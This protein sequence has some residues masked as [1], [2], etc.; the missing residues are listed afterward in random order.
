M[1]KGKPSP[2]VETLR[3]KLLNAAQAE[4]GDKGFAGARV[5]EIASCAGASK[6]ALYHHFGSKEGI[7]AAT[8]EEAYRRLRAPDQDIRTK[9]RKLE[10]KDALRTLIEHLFKPSI[11]T[12]RFQRIMHDENRFEAIHAQGLTSAKRAYADLLETIKD[13]LDRGETAGVFRPGIDPKQLY[14]FLAGVLVYR[15]TNAHTLTAMLDLTLDDEEGARRSRQ[16]AIELILDGL[17]PVEQ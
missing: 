17:R 15:L 1:A 9:V 14:V 7:F 11:G 4:F 8:V 12:V 13:I 5:E 10:P 3:E 16:S 2:D 6:Q